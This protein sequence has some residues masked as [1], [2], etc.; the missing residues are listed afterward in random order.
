MA[1]SV[2]KHKSQFLRLIMAKRFILFFI[3]T[4]DGNQI[5]CK[6]LTAF[7]LI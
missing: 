4:R 6:H 2:Q 7:F 3:W 5:D 1:T